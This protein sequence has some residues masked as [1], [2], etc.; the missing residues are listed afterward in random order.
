MLNRFSLIRANR[1]TDPSYPRFRVRAA[2]FADRERDA[3]ER[4]FAAVRAWRDNASFEAALRPYF[5]SA[6]RVARERL[7]EAFFPL[8]AFL[9]SRLA[10]S[11]VSWEAVSDGGS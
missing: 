6:F 7:V 10:C 8:F 1:S 3:A 4:F 2:F 11:F 9:R 5:L